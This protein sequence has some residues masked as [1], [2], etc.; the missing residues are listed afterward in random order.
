MKTKGEIPAFSTAMAA[1]IL[2]G[3]QSSITWEE[4]QAFPAGTAATAAAAL[5]A[6]LAACT[7]KS[8]RR[9]SYLT[10]MAMTCSWFLLFG[11]ACGI[12]ASEAKASRN[13]FR[14]GY[15]TLRGTAENIRK[16]GKYTLIE[17][18][19]GNR[20]AT[21]FIKK[22]KEFPCSYGDSI[23]SRCY[24]RNGTDGKA[25]AF[26]ISG[27]AFSNPAPSLRHRAKRIN[28]TLSG[29]I[30][31]LFAR[32]IGKEKSQI[33]ASITKA[34]LTGDRSGITEETGR[35]FS[36]S[37]TMHL[38]ALS[39]LH[40]GVIYTLI[41]SLLV[42]IPDKRTG[43]AIKRILTILFIWVFATVTGLGISIIRAALFITIR[44]TA[45]I[46]YRKVPGENTLGITAAIML[47]ADPYALYD[48]GFQLSFSAVAGI[49]LLAPA[50]EEIIDGTFR[51]RTIRKVLQNACITI[52]C[53]LTSGT[54]AMYHFGNFPKYFLLSNMLAI[55]ATGIAVYAGTALLVAG[56]IP[57][58]GELIC[59]ILHLTV[60][61][62]FRVS[63]I[64]S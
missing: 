55:P 52:I 17:T 14:E 37:G 29:R 38:L 25:I 42:A 30:D 60:T 47:T 31:S 32:H 15:A 2:A 7:F 44:E 11:T 58:A 49:I 54:V 51:N 46:F 8:A 21:L 27:K 16:T 5:A 53:Q 34:M 23:V 41:R 24:I 12:S 36:L 28:A 9:R 62:L 33:S 64:L 45:G 35:L 63:E 3:T 6:V 26:F 10:W 61:F 20:K 4:L 48:I 56:D 50:T 39:G 22:E 18:A 1:G 43:N 57:F 40:A 19:N 59:R 13:G